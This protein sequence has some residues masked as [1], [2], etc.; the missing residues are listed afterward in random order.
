MYTDI[1]PINVAILTN[2]ENI[3]LSGDFVAVSLMAGNHGVMSLCA[4]AITNEVIIEIK[5]ILANTTGR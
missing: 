3:L 2:C 1:K 5:R 4:T